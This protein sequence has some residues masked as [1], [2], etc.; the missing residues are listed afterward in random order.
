M[1]IAIALTAVVTAFM[2][3]LLANF[4]VAEKKI[5]RAITRHYE[6][7]SDQ[8]RRSAGVLLGPPILAG[9][10]V[11]VLLNGDEIFPSMLEAI[12]NARSS[13][14]FE[15]FIY[16]SGDI[17]DAFA[18]ALAERAR[19]G[20]AVHVLLDWVGSRKMDE[21]C[22]EQMR[23]SGAEV[24]H[25]HPL[26]WYHLHRL[27]NR[28]HRKLLVVDGRIGFT[29]G[30]GIGMQWTGH[31]QDPDHW[32]DTHFRVEGPVVAQMQSAFLDNWVKV[33]REVMHGARY[34]PALEPAGPLAAQMFRSSPSGGAESLQ[35]MMLLAIT[36]ASKS[37]LIGNSYF[38][39]D[40]L[41]RRALVAAAKRGVSVRIVVPGR[42]M[43]AKTV[44]HASRAL[45]GEL[46]EAGVEIFEYMP[47]MFHC[48][49]MIV[50]EHW[51]SVGS[52]NFD[53]RSFS[54]ND[55]ATLCVLDDDFAARMTQVFEV[56]RAASRRASLK[57]WQQRRIA[58][59]A[60]EFFASAIRTQL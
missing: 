2:V 15:T 34:F 50:D 12:R 13:I 46:L 11:E 28:T 45:W 42:Y 31:A 48:K 47:T 59:R 29:G 38:V 55:E 54:L 16:W 20:V 23:A 49:Y 53:N 36:A 37:I 33:R 21:E 7:R 39:P 32:R 4:R 5:E 40:G 44:R 56:D 9:N 24:E 22:L 27:N 58:R 60:F 19:A 6:M 41:M 18:D 51:V 17:G 52:A 8:F 26:H 14:T 57:R 3:M 1:W 25:F 35:L 43:D 30:V 10:R